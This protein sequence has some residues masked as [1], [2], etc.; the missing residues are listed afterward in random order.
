MK[1]TF[2]FLSI[3]LI[4]A[5]FSLGQEQRTLT[6]ET[7]RDPSLF[8][9][10]FIPRTWWLSDQSA[11][12]FDPRVPADQRTLERFDPRSG[13]RSPALD[14]KILTNEISRLYPDNPPQLPPVPPIISESGSRGLYLI[15]GDILVVEIP[16]STIRRIT[17]T[18]AAESGPQ[19]SPNGNLIAYVREKNIYVY[20][21]ASGNERPLT[22]DG[23]GTVLNGTLSW[24]YWEEVF[25]RQDIGYWWSPDSRALAFLRTDESNVSVQHYTDFTPWTPTVTTQRYP[26]VGEPNPTVR[27]GLTDLS[28][29]TTQWAALD[30][31]KF[32]YIMRIDWRPDGKSL[33]VRTLNRT[34]TDLDFY[35][36]ERATGKASFVMRDSNRGWI[37]VSDDL[38]FT[39]DGKYFIISSERDGYAHLYRFRIDGTLV[40][41]ITKGPWALSSSGP[42][43]WVRKAITG[44]DEKNGWIYFSAQEKTSLE[45]HLYRIRADGSAMKRLTEGDGTHGIF[46]SPDAQ[47][48]FDRF[49]SLNTAPSL[50]A[51][52]VATGK[53]RVLAAAD[54]AGFKDFNVQY[55]SLMT[56]PARD[57][58]K[59]PSS[60]TKPADFNLQKR[61]PVIVYVYGGPSAP[62][63]SNEFSSGSIWDNVLLNNGYLVLRVDNRAA[64][65]ISKSLENLL[66]NRTPGEVELN[67]LVDAVRWMKQQS[68]VDSTRIGIWG[69]SGGGTNTILAMTRSVE[70]KAGIAGAGVTDFRFYDSKWAEAMMK[71]EAENKKGYEE[72]SLLQYAGQ[73]HGK[74]ML[75]HGTHDDNVHIQNTWRFVD[76]LIKA[77]KLFELMVYPLR[78]HG[79]S[80]PAGARHLNN[81]M[82]DFWKR[83]L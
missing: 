37:N 13:K 41:Q 22:R 73:L 31:A 20:D 2:V 34:Q 82:L 3:V 78:K 43:F 28:T 6:L 74:L 24:V 79:V 1:R 8:K 4:A 30:E 55:P 17:S 11:Y 7:M 29:G 64:T 15:N 50:S 40:N 57:G 32:E 68:Y 67:D 75:I 52:E 46:M 70:F 44:V 38:Y 72:A 36:V 63:V 76:E 80:D 51:V 58:F 12:L 83:N 26:K 77:N 49:S 42:V 23:G 61:Y 16:T 81:V 45:K 5:S 47:Y 71:T 60:I 39:H 54:P 53:Q 59:L 62:T 66:L 14:Q 21:L 27:V 19:F 9:A 25:G 18:L 48:Y 35:S 69:W 56:I 10:F 65:G 33:F